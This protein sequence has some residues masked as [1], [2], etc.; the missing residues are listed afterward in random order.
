MPALEAQ[1]SAET[2]APARL[3][4]VRLGMSKRL[5]KR[6]AIGCG[7]RATDMQAGSM[8]KVSVGNTC[9]VTSNLDRSGNGQRTL[10]EQNIF[11][12]FFQ[13]WISQ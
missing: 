6:W 1:L 10:A 13:S 4:A 7:L 11:H 8:K 12:A 5:D 3:A 9:G 2:E